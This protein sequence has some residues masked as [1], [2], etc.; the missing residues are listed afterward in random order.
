MN[1]SLNETLKEL[2]DKAR[3]EGVTYFLEGLF[4]SSLLEGLELEKHQD[5]EAFAMVVVLLCEYLQDKAKG[6]PIFQL[7]CSDPERCDAY[8]LIIKMEAA[9]TLSHHREYIFAEIT[10]KRMEIENA[11]H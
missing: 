11:T 5:E 1:E 10:K 7:M 8:L 3:E 4:V 9:V 2:S 6:N